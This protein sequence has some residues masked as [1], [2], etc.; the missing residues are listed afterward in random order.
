MPFF[1][2]KEQKIEF[3]GE[4]LGGHS[5]FPKK[6]DVHLI[7]EPQ[8]LLVKELGLTIPYREIESIENMT[9]DKIS[10]K[11]VLLLGVVGALWKKEELYMVLT[12][13][14]KVINAEQEMVFKMEKIND[15]QP[16][17][18]MRMAE[19][20]QATITKEQAK[21]TIIT[22]EVVKTSCPHCRTLY[23]LTLDRCPHCGAYRK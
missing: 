14:D 2:K 23:D 15:A 17:I 3:K 10:A 8:N 5:A 19:A 6:R 18:Y 22:K 13:Q 16:A 11:R 4:Y 1:R 12:Y 9:K 20:K 7:L 21:E